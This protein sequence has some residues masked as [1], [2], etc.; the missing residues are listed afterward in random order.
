MCKEIIKW[1]DKG[2]IS[3]IAHSDRVSPVQYVPKKGGIIVIQ[4]ASN[5]LIL[6]RL[7]IGWWACMDYPKLN[8]STEKDYFFIDRKSVV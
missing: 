1:F 6:A 3:L 4:N 7:V 5:E 2:V 8:I